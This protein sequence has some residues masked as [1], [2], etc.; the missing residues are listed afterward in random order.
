MKSYRFA[1]GMIMMMAS[2]GYETDNQHA[3]L[4]KGIPAAAQRG[5][6]SV[7][8]EAS[9]TSDSDVAISGLYG[10]IDLMPGV[11]FAGGP[12]T[13]LQVKFKA[14][15]RGCTTA[16]DF[17]ASLTFTGERQ[18]LAIKRVK[19]DVCAGALAPVDINLN[20][21]GTYKPTAPVVVNGVE[22]PVMERIIY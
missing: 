14:L 21:Y 7:A 5:A 11:G 13:R 19:H 12:H 22:L 17:T 6:Q 15:G 4:T 16:R 8:D 2:C 20:V 9:L 10:W 3:A 18:V 1:L